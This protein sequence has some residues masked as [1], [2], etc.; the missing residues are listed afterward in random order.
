MSKVAIKSNTEK[1]HALS[2]KEIF[3]KLNTSANGITTEEAIKRKKI[4]GPNTLPLKK[5]P[6]LFIIFI[7][8]FLSPLIYVLIAAAILALSIGDVK[9][10]IFIFAVIFINA[11]IGTYQEYKAEKS[12]EALQSMIKIK[13]I[14]KRDE[15]KK[16]IDSIDLVPG[17]IVYLESG[18]KVPADLRLIE[19]NS[20]EIDESF[21]TGESIASLKNP[22]II[23]QEKGI[24]DRINCAF[25][26]STVTKGRGVGVVVQTGLS[27]EVGKIAEVVTGEHGAKPPLI[28]RMEKFSSQ[29]S[30]IVL[31]S[32]AIIAS[33][34]IYKGNPAISVIFL[35]VA[36][37]VSAIPEGLPV[38]LTVALTVATIRMSKRNVIVRKLTAV[39]SLGSCTYIASDKTGTLTVNQQTAKEIVMPYGRMFFVSGE[40]YNNKGEIIENDK[41]VKISKGSPEEELIITGIICNEGYLQKENEKWVSYGDAMDI[42]LLSLGYK[43]GINQTDILNEIKIINEIPYE[44][45]KKFAAKFYEKQKKNYCAIKGALE[46]ILLFCKFEYDKDGN[47]ININKEKITQQSLELARKGYRV[48]AFAGGEISETNEEAL[49][50][51][52]FLGLIAFIDPLRPEA[53]E[54]INKCKKAGIEVAMVTGDHPV[55]AFAIGKELGICQSEA[56]VVTGEQLEKL[57]DINS[58][59][60]IK[61]VTSSHVFARVSPIQKL[62]IV[63][64]LIK[65]GHFVAVT[66]D[67]VNDAPALKKAN[68]GVAMGSGTDVAKD[69]G[70][71]IVTD[72]NFASIVAGVEEGRFAY[73]NVRKVIYLLISTGAAEIILFFLAVFFTAHFFEG[74]VEPPLLAI[75][76][77][78][79]NL[80][81]NGIQSTALAFEGGEEGAMLKKPRKPT[82]GIFNG[83]MIKEI[84]TSALY[85]SLAAFGVWYYLLSTGVNSYTAR[86]ITLLLMVLL[87]NVHVFNCRSETISAFK[88]KISKNYFVV[89]SVIVAQIIH[90]LCMNNPFM[91]SL[92]KIEPVSIKEWFIVALISIGLLLVMETFKFINNIFL[93]KENGK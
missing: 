48:L 50:N 19:T 55:T 3:E 65:T 7:K 53:K 75:Q 37:A 81:T 60:F 73:D 46:K 59:Q 14:V 31:V 74:R 69:T 88:V 76:L 54:A 34:L 89:I 23:E 84:L 91:Q 40:G 86:N 51:L 38:A 67:G 63:D 47:K 64:T 6:S 71:M 85:M 12:A 10:S 66:G 29:I 79:L 5:P 26:G 22:D 80:V 27:T 20:L 49:K 72:D 87:E 57:G 2:I 58:E 92:L 15:H 1:W 90:V 24:S 61:K 33:Y 4:Y 93:I 62:Q 21:L 17:D 11:I 8:Q 36:L 42:A 13:A 43:S 35:A 82:E 41:P 30:I 83:L 78:W 44:S 68:I 39:E 32:A 18:I 52:T 56:E 9:D 70:S 45:E 16:E 25:A 28:I 77:L